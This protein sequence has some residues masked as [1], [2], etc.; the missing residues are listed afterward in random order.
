M[1]KQ[2]VN[3]KIYVTGAT[4]WVGKTFMHE[5]QSIIP[6]GEFNQKVIAFGSKENKV[7]STNYPPGKDIIIPIKPLSE[8]INYTS[9]ENI[10][11]FH[12]AFLTK[13]RITSYGARRFIDTNKRITSTVSEF[14]KKS[15]NS[16]VVNISS[17]AATAIEEKKRSAF[18]N[19]SDSYGVLK[20]DEEYTLTALSTT[21]VFR[22]YALTGRFIRDPQIFAIGDLLLK[23][24]KKKPLVITSTCPVIRS[25]AS[26]SDIA[27]C[28]IHW[29][30]SGDKEQDVIKASSH[31]V[32]LAALA[33]LI[34]K[35]YNLPPP[36][37]KQS[38]NPPNSYSCSPIEFHN[39]LVRY[40][41]RPLTL[42]EQ[43]VDTAKNLH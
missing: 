15:K 9:S 43:I 21:Q 22:I 8:L 17:G 14:L 2:T 19:E 32:T 7:T 40:G 35:I 37:V 24:I 18:T 29:L 13:D 16:R 31:V 12:S 25:Y 3:D 36:I 4:G 20:L 27:K 39:I 23:A 6:A 33:E 26:A 11:L 10:L 1:K 30:L 38:G 34:A 41:I 42:A 28:A 5:L